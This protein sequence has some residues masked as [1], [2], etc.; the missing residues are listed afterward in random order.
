[1]R[2][3]A[4]RYFNAAGADPEGE[5]GEDHDPETHLI[6]LVLDAAAGVRPDIAIF[7]NDYP[8]PDGTCVRDYIHVS[9][10]ADAHVL[11]LQMLERGEPCGALNLGTGIGVSVA[12]IVAAAR[13]VTGREIR[14][15]QAARRAGDPA[16]LLAD[17]RR[18][19]AALSWTPRLSSVTD[20]IATAW[21]WH[22]RGA[23][24]GDANSTQARH[25]QAH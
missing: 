11:A 23:N 18:A 7:G 5:I 16:V 10:L 6:P 14:V 20:I 22:R 2:S 24:S 21:N 25:A 15:R 12:E 17:P 8:T 3:I 1:V 4:L 9:D 19:R 13:A